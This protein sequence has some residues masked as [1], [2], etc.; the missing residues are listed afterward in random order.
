MPRVRASVRFSTRLSTR[1]ICPV[2]GL[3]L[4]SAQRSAAPSRHWSMM[5]C[6]PRVPIT[7]RTRMSK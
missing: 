2:S 6:A 5:A 7:S 4:I 1:S 3:R